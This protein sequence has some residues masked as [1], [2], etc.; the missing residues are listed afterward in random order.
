MQVAEDF[1]KFWN[2]PNCGGAIDGKHIRIVK[3]QNSGSYY[4]NYKGYCSVVLMAVVNAKYEFILVSVGGNGRLI[5]DEFNFNKML[6]NGKLN[7]PN[8]AVTKE[9]M[10]FVF[11]ADDAFPLTKHILKP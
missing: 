10:N 1:E 11:V 8:N 3:P 6:H 9:H 4:Y 2:F 7:V 5:F